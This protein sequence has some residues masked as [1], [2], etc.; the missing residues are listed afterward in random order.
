MSSET[1]DVVTDGDQSGASAGATGRSFI[2]DEATFEEQ[3]LRCQICRDKFENEERP[4]KSLP[5]NHTFCLPCLKQVFDHS[6]PATRRD[7]SWLDEG[8]HGALKCPQC[9][10]EIYLSRGGIA[11]LPNDHRVIQM[12]DFLSQAVAK[13]KNV[14]SKHERQP[15]NFFCKKCFLPVCRDCTVLD[16][17]EQQGHVIVDVTDAVSESSE[18]FDTMENKTKEILDKM[19]SRWDSLAN[20]SKR[21]DILERQLRVSI[22]DTFIEYRLLLERRQEALIKMVKTQVKDNKQKINARFIE[23]NEWGTQLQKLY[24][25]LTQSR[26]SNDLR[27][28]FTINQ[29]IKEKEGEFNNASQVF[30]DDLF[31][32]CTF[33]VP[34]EGQFLSEMS[35]LGEV[36]DKPDL[37]LKEPVPA[38]QLVLYDLEEQQERE[39]QYDRERPLPYDCDNLNPPH[40]DADPDSFDEEFLRA[41]TSRL[42]LAQTRELLATES[43]SDDGED[44]PEI[45]DLPIS[46]I[47]SQRRPRTTRRPVRDDNS[48][49]EQTIPRELLVPHSPNRSRGDVGE[50]SR[51]GRARRNQDFRVVRHSRF[52]QENPG[53]S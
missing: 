30:D 40:S 37:T 6:Q 2:V 26:A 53:E 49:I 9:R 23:V 13:S 21:L 4:P 33:E 44:P 8:L 5:C 52:N 29:K 16:H 51:A 10:V 1:G 43:T 22:K 20:A 25:S 48:A 18:E 28:L 14:C 34:N 11:Q 27:Q 15:L 35:G 19:K 38:Q 50:R 31:I 12:M 7:R 32:S 39:R 17:K 46:Q 36:S 42:R 45:S 41:I 47:L 3:F 24:D